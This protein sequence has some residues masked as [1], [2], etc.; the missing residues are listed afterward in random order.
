MSSN[1]VN[2]SLRMIKFLLTPH[3][4]CSYKKTM[5]NFIIFRLIF[6]SNSSIVF[7]TYFSTLKSYHTPSIINVSNHWF[8][9]PKQKRKAG[10]HNRNNCI[11][12]CALCTYFTTSTQKG[13]ALEK[14]PKS[15]TLL[16][17]H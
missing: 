1:V 16:I 8:Y 4:V 15:N 3:Q 2:F 7:S 10:N 12:T 14:T 6:C 17:S 11:C 13:F 9:G 5:M